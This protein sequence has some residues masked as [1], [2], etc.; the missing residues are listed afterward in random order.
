MTDP[1]TSSIIRILEGTLGNSEAVHN[2]SSHVTLS[3][4]DG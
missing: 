1:H 4:T 3:V 2:Q